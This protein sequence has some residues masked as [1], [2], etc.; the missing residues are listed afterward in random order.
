[1]RIDEGMPYGSINPPWTPQNCDRPAVWE[2]HGRFYDQNK[3]L[4]IPNVPLDEAELAAERERVAAE[5]EAKAAAEALSK[6]DDE[7]RAKE[8]SDRRAEERVKAAAAR[9]ATAVSW[10]TPPY[11]APDLDRPAHYQQGDRYLDEHGREIVPGVPLSAEAL[12]A[13]QA[14]EADCEGLLLTQLLDRASDT[15][16]HVL[17]A[18]GRTVIGPKCPH[19]AAQI[20]EQM[21]LLLRRQPNLRIPR[22]RPAG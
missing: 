14:A 12:A 4:I 6:A 21:R 15:P 5:A 13:A 11:T 1:M 20:Q 10:V 2:Q 17:L 9:A 8:E 22:I 18:V 16:F 3:L 19:S 7:A